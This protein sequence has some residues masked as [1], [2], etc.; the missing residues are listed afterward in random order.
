MIP[1]LKSCVARVARRGPTSARPR[2]P[3]PARAP[4]GVLHPRGHRHDDRRQG[5]RVMTHLDPARS[6]DIQALDAEHGMQTYG[7]LPVAFVRGEGVKLWDSEGKEYLDFLGGLAVTVARARAPGGRRRARRPGPHAAARVEPLLQRVAAAG[8]G[9]ARRAARR[10]RQGVLR[11]LRR[12]G[13]RVRDQARPPVRPGQRRP[14]PVPRALGVGLV[15]RPHAHHARRHRPAPEAG[16]VPAA[17][18]RVPP[19]G[20]RRPRRAGGGDGRAGVRGDARTDPGRGRRAAVAARLPRR[21]AR[22][23]RRA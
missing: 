21:R 15:P 2:R 8:R 12:R 14:R 10:R 20:V 3:H 22:A 9:A 11:Q 1:K 18:G 19:G 5:R 7:R 16:D 6:T 4:V 17:A 13:Q 23:V